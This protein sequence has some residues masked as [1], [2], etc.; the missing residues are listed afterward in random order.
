MKWSTI[1]N[2]VLNFDIFFSTITVFVILL[3]FP[4]LFNFQ[5]FEPFKEAIADF[6]ITDVYFSKILPG[7]NNPKE[8]DVIVVNTSI[9]TNNGLKEMDQI[10][11]AET[12]SRI[13]QASPSVIGLDLILKNEEDPALNSQ[14]A[15]ILQST[16]N[17]VLSCNFLDW[18]KNTQR[19]T[20]QISSPS[21]FTKNASIGFSNFQTDKD[22]RHSTIRTMVPEL[23]YKDSVYYAFSMQVARKYNPEAVERFI[24]RNNDKET[25]N[26]IGNFEKYEIVDASEILDGNVDMNIFKNMIVIMAPFDVS[27]QSDDLKRIYY[28]PLNVKTAGRTFPDM[29][30]IFIHANI[31]SMLLTDQYFEEMPLWMSIVS[32]FLVCYINM[33]IFLYISNKNKKWFEISALFFFLIES[34]SIAYATVHAFHYYKYEL[35]LTMPIVASAL[36]IFIFELYYDTVKPLSIIIYLRLIKNRY[37]FEKR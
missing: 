27:S 14:I 4:Y 23:F 18:D 36:S 7:I 1:K 6:Q 25:I 11:V 16:P 9:M 13:N 2:N 26:F 8:T 35:R 37:F 32:A 12:I 15:N 34:L 31:I 3:L 21:D 33:A 17:L 5:I 30:A 10:E 29:Y 22:K 19:F 20:K 28:T 24:K